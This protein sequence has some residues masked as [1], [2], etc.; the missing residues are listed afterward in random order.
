MNEFSRQIVRS[1]GSSPPVVAAGREYL[2]AIGTRLDNLD[3]ASGAIEGFDRQGQRL[4]RHS[5]IGLLQALPCFT[6]DCLLDTP[7]GRRPAGALKPGDM[8]VTRDHGLRQVQWVGNCHF[9]WRL[10][11][12]FPIL[13][14]IVIEAGAL[15]PGLPQRSCRMSPNHGLLLEQAEGAL[16]P[17]HTLIGR[18]GVGQSRDLSVTYL[19]ILLD[20]HALVRADGMWCESFLPTA[21]TVAALPQAEA[22]AL[23]A[24][25]SAMP[26]IEE[27]Y[28][29]VTEGSAAPLC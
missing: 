22:R 13:R 11:G 10:L 24:A 28:A 20:C 29:R 3:R 16:T 15:G 18:T 7:T 21:A 2:A 14:P 26:P 17:A 12:L 5:T 9:D 19:P 23:S 1:G 6:A 25:L 27:H 4:A 8:L